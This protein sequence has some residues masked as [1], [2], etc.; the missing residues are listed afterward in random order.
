M[1]AV[2]G[3]S[4]TIGSLVAGRLATHH[5]LRL[6]TRHPERLAGSFADAELVRADYSDPPSLRRALQGVDAALLVTNDPLADHDR[7]FV[8]AARSAGV[9]HL[10]KL[11][12]AAVEDAGADDLITSWQRRNERIIRSSGLDW[13]FLRPRAFMSNA[14]SWAPGIRSDGVVRALHGASLNSCVDPR[15]VADVAV[16]ALARKLPVGTAHRLTGPTALSPRMQTAL[17]SRALGRSLTFEELDA[18]QARAHL[19]RQL[20]RPVAE[21]LLRSAQRQYAGAK[22]Q[23]TTEVEDLLGRPARSFRTWA[24]DHAYRFTERT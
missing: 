8:Q 18:G 11:S 14:L 6:L 19:E 20:P 1:I 23:V 13:T 3:A 15:D 9:R 22:R 7:P 5:A 12:A 10:V 17:L 24:T 21:A 16:Q 4:G 2:T